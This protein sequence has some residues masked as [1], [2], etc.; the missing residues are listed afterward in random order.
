[1]LTELD[2]SM[3][4]RCGLCRVV[5]PMYA[6]SSGWDSNTPKAK[7]MLA[8]GL[9]RGEVEASDELVRI[10]NQCS[11][12]ME[13]EVNCP[14]G[15]KVTEIIREAREALVGKGVALHCS[16]EGV[17]E[18][19]A[20]ITSKEGLKRDWHNTI[21]G[22]FQEAGEI[23]YF[24]G[25]FTFVEPLLEF[26]VGAEKIA[27]GAVKILNRA[28]IKPGIPEEL[29]CCGHDA[30]WAGDR[31]L[32]NELR[33]KNMRMLKDA[34]VVVTS[35]AE[36]YRTLKKDYALNA[37]VYHMSQFVANL[38]E[39]G[40][41]EVKQNKE[42]ITFHDPCRL[43]RHTGEYEAPRAVLKRIGDYKEM[44]KFGRNATCCG[45]GAWLNCNEYSKLI[46]IGRL[47]EAAAVADTLITGCPKCLIHF[48]C[49]ITE[50][51]SIEGLPEI[52]IRDFTEFVASNLK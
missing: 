5:C 31:S 46:R 41:L 50:P 34:R 8:L 16:H 14:A 35:C 1:M 24:P 44:A 42:R 4:I 17:F 2:L 11:T 23:V 39:E 37:D 47:K 49:L 7:A 21:E 18:S 22:D 9:R 6:K 32:F 20:R 36:G 27:S 15:A 38:I 43:G 25:C 52:E 19:I 30:L 40:K 33:E 3:C 45:V 51:E 29:A 26:E 10:F 48:R 28:G 13:C 12:C